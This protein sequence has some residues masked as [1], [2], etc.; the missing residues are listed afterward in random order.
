MDAAVKS[1]L[2][3]TEPPRF[4]A[5]AVRGLAGSSFKH[6]HLAA[7]HLS[8]FRFGVVLRQPIKSA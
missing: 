1:G 3:A 8:A 7:C 5:L 6:E 2:L 4:P